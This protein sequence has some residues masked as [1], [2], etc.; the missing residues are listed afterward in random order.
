VVLLLFLKIKFKNCGLLFR[1]PFG[2]LSVSYCLVFTVLLNN[3][4]L[5]PVSFDFVLDFFRDFSGIFYSSPDPG[6]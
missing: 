2:F 5:A 1:F 4:E 3:K 6:Q